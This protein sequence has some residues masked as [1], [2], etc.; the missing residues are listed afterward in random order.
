MLIFV[1]LFAN[2]IINLWMNFRSF[3]KSGELFGAGTFM[4]MYEC[5]IVRSIK[6]FSVMI[7][8][9]TVGRKTHVLEIISFFIHCIFCFVSLRLLCNCSVNFLHPPMVGVCK[10]LHGEKAPNAYMLHWRA[11]NYFIIRFMHT[12]QNGYVRA[13]VWTCCVGISTFKCYLN[14]QTER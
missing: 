13:L 7:V 2:V 12:N 3:Y 5:V 9:E 4:Y 8:G 10:W 14:I 6:T 1:F 11:F